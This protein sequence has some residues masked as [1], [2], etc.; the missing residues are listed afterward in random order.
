MNFIYKLMKPIVPVIHIRG[1]IGLQTY[2]SIIPI[3]VDQVEYILR[4]I[5][6]GRAKALAVVVN[7]KG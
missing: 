3:S 5:P 6:F 1:G 7:S 4:H 2:L